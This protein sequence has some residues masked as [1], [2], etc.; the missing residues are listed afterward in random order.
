MRLIAET[1]SASSN[2]ANTSAAA[3]GLML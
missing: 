3:L 2:S 1:A